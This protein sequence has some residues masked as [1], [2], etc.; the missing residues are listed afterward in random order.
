MLR[1]VVAI[2]LIVAWFAFRKAGESQFVTE[3][4]STIA[5]EPEADAAPI[6]S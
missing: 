1:G 5:V 4:L 2:G 3:S 6:E